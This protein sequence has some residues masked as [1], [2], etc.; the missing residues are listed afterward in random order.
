MKRSPPLNLETEV[1]GVEELATLAQTS[2][3][4]VL[5]WIERRLHDIAESERQYFARKFNSGR[6]AGYILARRH[7][8]VEQYIAGSPK[9]RR[10]Q[11]T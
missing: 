2:R 4:A 10:K 7:P 1:I 3:Q 9:S 11:P 8:L 6:T 5:T